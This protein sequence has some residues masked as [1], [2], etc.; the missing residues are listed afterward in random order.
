MRKILR[1]AA[2][3]IGKS[4]TFHAAGRSPDT[5]AR[6]ASAGTATTVQRASGLPARHSHKRPSTRAREL[7]SPFILAMLAGAL[8][9]SVVLFVLPRALIT[10]HVATEPLA[11][12]VTL[13]LDT[14]VTEARPEDGA[15]PARH[16]RVEE[17]VERDFPIA[18]MQE[19]GNRAAG[20]VDVV[21]ATD[22][23]QGIKAGTRLISTTGV[24]VRVQR[25]TI[26]PRQSRLPAR[27]VADQG[28]TAGN[29]SPQRLTMP[30]LSTSAQHVLYGDV[31]TALSGGS[32]Q[33]VR[34]LAD[35]DIEHAKQE[36]RT[37]SEARLR[38][39]VQ[40]ELPSKTDAKNTQTLLE[41]SDL[42]RIHVEVLETTPSLGG[43]G[44]AVHVR[45]RVSAE[46]LTTTLEGLQQLIE[47][48]VRTRVGPGKDIA[49]I[50][51]LQDLRVVS[52]DWGTRRATVSLHV[53]TIVLPDL[54]GTDLP[55]RLA[56]R[57]PESA[58]ELLK[59]LPG[60]RLTTVVLS[61]VWARRVPGNPR[62]IHIRRVLTPAR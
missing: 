60:V 21:N 25:G 10:V 41:R 39:R 58:E 30:G 35:E 26:I 33:L 42:L 37:D 23:T 18:T 22:T 9:T 59:G 50:G 62:N 27:V 16:V 14:S 56:G 29:L 57:T 38:T 53:E 2:A 49:D 34:V 17:V 51:N 45:A 55:A 19:R 36:L 52:V 31:L 8:F 5:P 61:P 11:T 48:I 32:E 3:E 54:L 20:F 6:A 28:G 1:S 12:D 47:A 40:A 24:V 43:I 46:S 13:T 15:L 7:H 44:E 4:V